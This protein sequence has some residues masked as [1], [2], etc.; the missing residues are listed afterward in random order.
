MFN[1]TDANHQEIV[2]ALQTIGA[3]VQDLSQVGAGCPD[4]LV[5]YKKQNY[6]TVC[7]KVNPD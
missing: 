5:G 6:L 4:I 2:A 1:R 3:T 7:V